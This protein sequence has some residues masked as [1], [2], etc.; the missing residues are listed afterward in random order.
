[1]KLMIRDQ[2]DSFLYI[3]ALSFIGKGFSVGITAVFLGPTFVLVRESLD[4]SNST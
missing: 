3:G 2:N 4:A 1:M